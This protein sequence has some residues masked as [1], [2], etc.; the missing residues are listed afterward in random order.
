MLEIVGIFE[1]LNNNILLGF[2]LLSVIFILGTKSFTVNEMCRVR[3]LF[4]PTVRERE[5]KLKYN[6]ICSC[7]VLLYRQ[8]FKVYI[9]SWG[10][11]NKTK[12]IANMDL[13]TPSTYSSSEI[14][15][16]NSIEIIY[17]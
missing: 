4:R 12:Q 11:K 6:V 13:Y 5:R 9:H 7:S 14:Y 17:S 15:V 10:L 3:V 2:S 1:H 16:Q 8:A